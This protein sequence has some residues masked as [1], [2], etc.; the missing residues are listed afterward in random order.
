MRQVAA[1]AVVGIGLGLSAVVRAQASP[2][3]SRTLAFRCADVI[4]VGDGGEARPR[5]ITTRTGESVDSWPRWSPDGRRIAFM[6]EVART[7]LHIRN[8]L[9]VVDADGSHRRRLISGLP[10]PAFTQPFDWSP[11]SRR[12]AVTRSRDPA[13]IF[14]RPD[15]YL[16]D[17]VTRS[18]RRLTRHPYFDGHPSW[19]GSRLLYA[20][21]TDEAQVRPRPVD[22]LRVIEGAARR[23]RLVRRIPGPILDIAAS[24]DGRRVLVIDGGAAGSGLSV[25][26]VGSRSLRALASGGVLWTAAGR[27]VGLDG[28]VFDARLRPAA[29]R[30]PWLP[31]DSP[32][33]TP[34]GSLVVCTV[35]YGADARDTSRGSDL[36]L[37]DPAS[38]VRTPL[39]ADATS[40]DGRWRPSS[41]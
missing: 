30:P 21:V 22:E 40:S 10:Y 35:D 27:L 39:T 37:L 2:L 13:D 3:G 17:V 12:I 4:C 25:V 19:R 38:G 24:P 36:V 32:D 15:L 34:D 8:E 28:T 29:R 33:V 9:V 11:D 14:L 26:N 20:R 23:D 5:A 18:A 7:N 31:C 16:V 6:H 1:I 41:G